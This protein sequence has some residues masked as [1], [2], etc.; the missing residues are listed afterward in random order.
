DTATTTLLSNTFF[1]IGLDTLTNGNKAFINFTQNLLEKKVPLLLP[2]E[3]VVVEILEDVK[4]W[5]GLVAACRKM[6]DAGYTLALDDFVYSPELL[7]LIALADIIKID[8]RATPAD[9]ISAYLAQLPQ[10]KIHLLAEKVETAEEFEAA[11]ALGF[12]LFQGYFFCRPEMIKGREIQGSQLNLLNIM[13]QANRPDFSVEALAA[14]ISRDV[15]F[16]YKLFKYANATF[17]GRTIKVSSVRDAMV[18]LGES[19]IRRFVSLVAM[20]RLA[21]G[22]TDELIRMASVR[23]KF[24][25]LLSMAADEPA[26][27]PE[28]FTMG[29]FSLIDAI[30]E[31]PM[32]QAVAPL[33]LSDAIKAALIHEKGH[34][35]GYL[36]LMRAYEYGQWEQVS[37][38]AGALKI[39]PET[40]PSFYLHA[41]RWA[42]A[43]RKP[44][45]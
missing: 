31:H 8:F 16:S 13:I 40:I 5:A 3:I 22:K 23:G 24:C 21:E 30:L 33:P 17:F 4:P 19:E 42:D 2:K 7:P 43:V 20:S 29:M 14:L 44:V 27:P 37:R 25:E 18:Y 11:K 1:S 10:K 34:L 36:E 26:P 32:A 12:D 6:A 38:T 39:N 15:G 9:T 35:F 41:C 45:W 28:M